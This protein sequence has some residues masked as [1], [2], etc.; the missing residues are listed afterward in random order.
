MTS[1]NNWLPLKQPLGELNI[2]WLSASVGLIF[3]L[4]VSRYNA[5][6]EER[7]V[8]YEVDIPKPCLPGWHEDQSSGMKDALEIRD[9]GHDRS[10]RYFT[11]QRLF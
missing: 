9:V 8:G 10:T 1:F 11:F 2:F 7:A 3:I 4:L 6:S 5:R